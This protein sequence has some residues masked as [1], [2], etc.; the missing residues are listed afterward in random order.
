[1]RAAFGISFSCTT[2]II[3]ISSVLHLTTRYTPKKFVQQKHTTDIP[4]HVQQCTHVCYLLTT[5]KNGFLK[6]GNQEN[7]VDCDI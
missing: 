6:N 4:K 1:M 7:V 3:T 5:E 2:R